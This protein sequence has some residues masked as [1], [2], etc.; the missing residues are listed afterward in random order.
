MT[1]AHCGARCSCCGM[2]LCAAN[3]ALDSMFV[4]E[5][6]AMSLLP[7][8][9]VL[10]VTRCPDF[11]EDCA[12]M[13]LA[14]VEKCMRGVAGIVKQQLVTLEPLKGICVELQRRQ[15]ATVCDGASG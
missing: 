1:I 6:A 3:V 11:D 15:A 8:V 14:D 12:A 2:S 7:V 5:E 13:P 10:T 4:S 9:D